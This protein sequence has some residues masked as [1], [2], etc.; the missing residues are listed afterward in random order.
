MTFSNDVRRADRAGRKSPIS[1]PVLVARL[2]LLE[3]VDASFVRVGRPCGR[4]ELTSGSSQ[5]SCPAAR[6][7]VIDRNTSE[8]SSRLDVLLHACCRRLV[9]GYFFS[10]MMKL[11]SSVKPS[12]GQ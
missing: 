1:E 6:F 9:N 2:A 5:L 3:H 8:A 12:L 4:H 10:G 7:G 11:R